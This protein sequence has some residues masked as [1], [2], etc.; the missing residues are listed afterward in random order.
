MVE[1]IPR[2]SRLASTYIGEYM[3]TAE[4]ACNKKFAAN[5]AIVKVN[6]VITDVLTLKHVITKN[7]SLLF[8]DKVRLDSER[9]DVK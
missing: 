2:D 4:Q 6:I 3:R 8:V 1:S 7:C 5:S 9:L